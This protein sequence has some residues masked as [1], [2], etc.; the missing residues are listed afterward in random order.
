MNGLAPF[1]PAS[2]AVYLVFILV[3]S[4]VCAHLTKRVLPIKE[5]LFSGVY[6]G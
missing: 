6:Y 4:N 1:V 3:G 5:F 2:A